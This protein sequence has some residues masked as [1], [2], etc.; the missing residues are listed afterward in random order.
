MK[1]AAQ[2]NVSVARSKAEIEEIV[3][4]Y[5][6]S[7]FGSATDTVQNRA[8]IQFVISKW[9]VRFILPLPERSSLAYDGR[10]HARNQTEL[11]RAWEQA[12][13]QRWRALALAIKAK[14]EAVESR[15]TTFEE[16]FL[17]H[18]VVPGTGRT[19]GD[20]LL[21]ELEQLTTSKGTPTLLEFR[22][23]DS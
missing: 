17:A 4:R 19:V 2:T 20:H 7:Q 9:M 16:E 3:S 14:L 11:D 6:A 5:G 18:V 23:A 13:R 15:I 10:K 22:G 1:Y 12:C 21:P 8:M